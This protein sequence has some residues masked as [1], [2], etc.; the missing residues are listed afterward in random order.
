MPA[1]VRWVLLFLLRCLRDFGYLMVCIPH[2]P[3]PPPSRPAPAPGH[4]E[5]V[6]PLRALPRQER[7][8]WKDLEKQLR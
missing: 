2:P 4:P 6:T 3:Q 7:R 1:S 5:Q 8:R